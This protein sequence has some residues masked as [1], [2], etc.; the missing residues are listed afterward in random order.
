M[1]V[2][3]RPPRLLLNF[4]T[5]VSLVLCV[6]TLVLWARS[7]SNPDVLP[8]PSLWRAV[9]LRGQLSV[10]DQPRFDRDFDRSLAEWN[11]LPG[12]GWRWHRYSPAIQ[13][14]YLVASPPPGFK[15]PAPVTRHNVPFA[16]PMALILTAALPSIRLVRAARAYRRRRL[17]L[18]PACGYDLRA[19][20]ERCPECGRTTS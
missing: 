5:A 1:P 15:Q 13:R 10:D 3:R 4:A 16:A 9:A 17:R 14:E 8:L 19:T 18:C 12:L 2:R 20:P 7:Y 6:A 11:S